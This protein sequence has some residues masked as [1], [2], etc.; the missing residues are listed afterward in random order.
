VQVVEHERERPLERSRA[1]QAVD[2]CEHHVPVL[3]G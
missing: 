2:R 1:Q 3:V